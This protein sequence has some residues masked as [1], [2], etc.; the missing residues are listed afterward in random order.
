MLRTC[1]GVAVAVLLSAGAVCLGEAAAR[2]PL[3]DKPAGLQSGKAA[4]EVQIKG[5]FF[6]DKKKNEVVDIKI[7]LTSTAAGEYDAVYKFRWSKKD[8]T[9]KGTVK[10][11]LKNGEVSGTGGPPDGSRSFTFTGKAANGVIACQHAETTQGRAGPTGDM[12]LKVL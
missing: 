11:D 6:W 9:W 1:C 3:G 8:L 4:K 12:T 5:T 7:A 10:G 2:K